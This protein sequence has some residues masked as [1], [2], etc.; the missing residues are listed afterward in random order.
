[1]TARTNL[2]TASKKVDSIKEESYEVNYSDEYP[3]SVFETS[4]RQTPL[5]VKKTNN[6][7]S[8]KT[9][10]Q[11]KLGRSKSTIAPKLQNLMQEL[12]NPQNYNGTK[13]YSNIQS[14]P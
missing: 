2:R 11:G 8:E 12:K 6:V 9:L 7:N 10:T 1:M 14:F 4:I 3:A 13:I 5:K